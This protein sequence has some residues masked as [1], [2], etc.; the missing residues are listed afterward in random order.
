MGE[1]REKASETLPQLETLLRDDSSAV[2]VH[3]AVA[4]WKIDGRTAALAPFV[5]EGLRGDAGLAG[6]AANC[7]REMGVAVEN[8]VPALVELLTNATAAWQRGAAAAALGGMGIAAIPFIPALLAATND[9]DESV[10]CTAFQVL[11]EL[12]SLARTADV[13]LIESPLPVQDQSF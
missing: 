13:I 1:F 8:V 12:R 5:L 9:S 2:R 10:A 6:H 11:R 3:A 4:I 7:L